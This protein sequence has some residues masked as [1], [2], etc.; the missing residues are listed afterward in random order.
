MRLHDK[1]AIITGGTF[2]IGESTAL[3]FAKEGAKVVIAA[4][5]LEKG[6]KVVQKIKELGGEAIFVKT[7]VSKEDDVKNLL[8]KLSM[9]LVK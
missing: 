2:G 6:E 1:V 4:R 3:L 8:K 9:F 7:D 5:N